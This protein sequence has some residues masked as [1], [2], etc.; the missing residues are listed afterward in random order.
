MSTRQ[1]SDIAKMGYDL[2]FGAKQPER[3]KFSYDESQHIFVKAII[4]KAAEMSGIP[5][6]YEG[7]LD[8]RH[9]FSNPTFK[10]NFYNLVVETLESIIPNVIIST[11]DNFVDVKNLNFGEKPIFRIDSPNLFVV[12]RTAF[13]NTNVTRQKLDNRVLELNPVARIVKIGEDLYNVLS[14]NSPWDVWVNKVGMSIVAQIKLDIYNTL[15][16][17]FDATNAN[18]M[19]QGAFSATTF[20]TIVQRVRAATG[21]L[22]PVC[23]GTRLALAQVLPLNGWSPPNGY[24]GFMSPNMMDEYN[25]GGYLGRF[26]GTPLIEVDAAVAWDGSYNFLTNDNFLYITTTADKPVKLAFAGPMLMFDNMANLPQDQVFELSTQQAWDLGIL[27]AAP[28]GIYML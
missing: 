2:Y 24:P 15:V 12:S 8:Y 5:F 17:S 18:F 21:G 9:V 25:T 22:Q 7:K 14:G 26:M 16:N 13:G 20:N 23:F 19:Y 6:K 10:H 1:M 28:Y 3:L 4:D 11:Y 27:T